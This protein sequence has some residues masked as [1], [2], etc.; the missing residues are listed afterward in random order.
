MLENMLG[1]FDWN[2]F[3]DMLMTGEAHR[4]LLVGIIVMVCS[5]LMY[6]FL[7]IGSYSDKAKIYAK[8]GIYMSLFP[9]VQAIWVALS[10]MNG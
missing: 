6:M 10:N 5:S 1:N 8:I 2:K 4:H 7:A 9:L 3:V